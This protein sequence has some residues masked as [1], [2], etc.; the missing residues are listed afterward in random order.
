MLV[1]DVVD[2]VLGGS[3]QHQPAHAADHHQHE[4]EGQYLAA[5]PHHFADV[6]PQ[7]AQAF[8]RAFFRSLLRNHCCLNY[9]MGCAP[10][11]TGCQNSDAYSILGNFRI[12][13]PQLEARVLRREAA[14][15]EIPVLL[16]DA[17]QRGGGELHVPAAA[18]GV[19]AGKLGERHATGLRVSAEGAHAHHTYSAAEAIR[20]H[21]C[22]LSR[23]R[24]AADRTPAGAGAVPASAG[25]KMR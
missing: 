1:D 9:C 2:Q 7:F 8:G 14:R 23:H 11:A 22:V 18:V 10:C 4:A 19:D 17:A 20:V 24:S 21:G 15:Q 16:C 3:R 12:R 13:L 25:A 6:R 5:R